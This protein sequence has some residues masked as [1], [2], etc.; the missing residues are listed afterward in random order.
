[1]KTHGISGWADLR[2]ESDGPTHRPARHGDAQ[3]PTGDVIAGNDVQTLLTASAV[4]VAV[5]DFLTFDCAK[6]VL[7][8]LAKSMPMSVTHGP[9]RQL[10]AATPFALCRATNA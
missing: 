10:N 8:N 1:M 3:R 2:S 9:I 6:Q 4:G 5:L 7:I